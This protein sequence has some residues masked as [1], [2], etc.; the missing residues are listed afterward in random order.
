MKPRFRFHSRLHVLVEVL[1]LAGLFGMTLPGCGSRTSPAPTGE[2][3]TGPSEPAVPSASPGVALSPT[4]GTA[5][6]VLKRM[7]EAYKSATSYRDDAVIELSGTQNGQRQRVTFANTVAMQRPNKIR[8]EIDNGTLLCD[9]VSTYGFVRD[10]P[11][12]ILRVPASPELSVKSLYPDVL[13]A[14][15]MMQSPARSFSWLPLQLL[16]LLTE[17]PMKTLVLDAQGLNL[18]EPASIEQSPCDRVQLLTSNGPG[19]FWIDQATSVLRRFEVPANDF[20][21]NAEAQQFLDPSL[22]MEFRDAQLNPPITPEAFQFKVPEG[23]T[24]AS[25]LVLP[26]LQVLGQPIPNFQFTDAAGNAISLESLK[27]K[28]VVMELWTSKTLPCRPVLQAASKAYAQIPNRDDVVMMAVNVEPPNVQSDS[29]QTVL[30]DWGVELPLYRDL[31]QSVINHFG[32]NTLP[33]TIMVDKKGNIQSLQAGLLENMDALLTK[34][35]E[36][37]QQGEEVYR[38]A[39]TQF[40]NERAS[41]EMMIEQSIADDIYCP[42]PVIPRAQVRS[43]TEPTKLKI[44]KLWSCDQL[45]HPGNITVVPSDSGSPRILVIDD[46]V[47]VAELNTDGTI[48]VNHALELQGNEVVTVLRTAVDKTTKRYF[49]GTARGIQR[50]HLFDADFK[51]LL[52]YPDVQ[53]PGIVDAQLTD[54]KGDGN[55]EMILGY[56][57]AAGV[58]AV[59]LHGKRLWSNN[60]MVDALRVAPL[61]PDSS[62]RRNILAMN[63]GVG[64]GT[65]IELDSEGKRLRE[66]AVPGY[67]V[68][69]VVADDLDGNG[70]SEICVLA[71]AVT[72]DGQPASDK[73]DA[74][75]IDGD[76]KP[77]WRHPLVRGVHQEQIEPVTTG[78]VFPSG[79][80][81]WL[82]VSADG[83]I[84]IVA[85]DG[86]LVDSFAYG[87]ALSGLATASWD[88]KPVLLVATPEAVEAWQIQSSPSQGNQE[89]GQ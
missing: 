77:L 60:S 46:L 49:L 15:S 53:N 87:A 54:L 84:T 71:M 25:A 35:I 72:P 81:Q 75:G 67:S 47:S 33:V 69:W 2:A 78:N 41:F 76:G 23:M 3:S 85:A 36:R 16:L 70:V 32:I 89:G 86:Q 11:G 6:E 82:I 63:G 29:L 4:K 27:G 56:G 22:V 68:G 44:T 18:L 13:L 57:G 9:G 40:E 73:I 64:G 42:R 66:I 58:H 1:L 10:L 34:V 5:E 50:V 51:T 14:R 39:F 30:K 55:L 37:L 43:R 8:M 88:G 61:S 59:D 52:V 7:I 17:S 24:T 26:I 45:K 19:V 74:M 79:P 12:Q 28:V 38:S 83:V 62:G 21:R 20:R 65:L 48:A 80:N 31:Q